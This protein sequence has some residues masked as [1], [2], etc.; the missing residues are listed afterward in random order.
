ENRIS[1]TRISRDV[2]RAQ[3]RIVL[4]PSAYAEQPEPSAETG[5]DYVPGQWSE[6]A[7]GFEPEPELETDHQIEPEQIEPEQDFHIFDVF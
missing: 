2:Y 4:T 7:P 5:T 3:N 1:R 6:P